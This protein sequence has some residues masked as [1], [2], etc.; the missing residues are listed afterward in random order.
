[1]STAFKSWHRLLLTPFNIILT[2]ITRLG[3]YLS[4][5]FLFLM[6]IYNYG[7]LL[8]SYNHPNDSALT[9][10]YNASWIPIYLTFQVDYKP[11]DFWHPSEDVTTAAWP[12]YLSTLLTWF[13]FKPK[14][15][16]YSQN[17]FHIAA[18][19]LLNLNK[20]T[21]PA[22]FLRNYYIALTKNAGHINT[23]QIRF[24]LSLISLP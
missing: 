20:K 11:L 15:E 2:F 19:Y 23:Y 18:N 21:C 6:I 5:R 3:A 7:H 13:Y 17:L 22:A 4:F 12:I 9:L 24:I 14:W 8:L 1:M 10:P 16:F